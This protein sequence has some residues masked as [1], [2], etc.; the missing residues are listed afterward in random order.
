MV[1]ASG[2][3]VPWD[4]LPP[5]VHAGVA[6]L[7]GS[8]VVAAQTQRGGFSPGSADRVVCEDGT[9]AFVKTALASANP[10]V[11]GIHR[12][13]AAISAWLP[14]SVA[15]PRLLGAI[16]E[17]EWVAIVFEDVDG[18]Q[19]PVPWRGAHVEAV[20][21]ALAGVAATPID[22]AGRMV[23]GDAVDELAPLTAAWGRLAAD[24]AGLDRVLAG[25]LG[26]WLRERMPI[27]AGHETSHFDVVQGETLVHFDIRSD[28]TLIRPDGS[29]VLVDWLWAMRGAPWLD[30][31][32]LGF[33]IRLYDP[34]YDVEGLLRGHPALDGVPPE[35]VTATLTAFGGHLLDGSRRPDPPG[36][37]TLRAFQRDQALAIL[38]W[39]RD[40]EAGDSSR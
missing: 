6:D 30:L 18:A 5:D 13:E 31:V 2:V 20:A 23:L 1:E 8:R 33:N 19:P 35:R 14:G 10:E 26:P 38:R 16:D 3:R 24:P 25:D 34:A 7:L 4:A 17:A 21:A 15:A 28:N 22:S 40:R 39:V 12:R 27:W 11:L 36:L 9:R 29:A 37:P 32:L